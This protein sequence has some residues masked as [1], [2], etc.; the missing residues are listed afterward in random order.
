MRH[1][2]HFDKK[3]KAPRKGQNS[4]LQNAFVPVTIII[5]NA[6]KDSSDS[7]TKCGYTD[8]LFSCSKQT[9]PVGKSVAFCRLLPGQNAGRP[10]QGAFDGS[11]KIGSLWFPQN[12]QSVETI[13]VFPGLPKK[14]MIFDAFRRHVHKSRRIIAQ[15]AHKNCRKFGK[16]CS[17]THGMGGG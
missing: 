5:L 17:C 1:P 8:P 15:D 12:R 11:C 16:K 13:P 4:P 10:R 7:C 9:H 3:E 14:R 2:P 6:E